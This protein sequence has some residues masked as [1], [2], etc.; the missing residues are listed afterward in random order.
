MEIFKV[1]ILELKILFE[2]LVVV[3]ISSQ[4]ERGKIVYQQGLVV[5]NRNY[6]SYFKQKGIEQREVGVYNIV[7][8]VGGFFCFCCQ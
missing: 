2:G 6:M 3:K 1:F 8:K 5:G 7:G 4:W